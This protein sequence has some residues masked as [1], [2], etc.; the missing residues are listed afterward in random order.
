MGLKWASSAC[1]PTYILKVDDDIV[2]NLESTYKLLTKL[3]SRDNLLMGYMLNNTK[4]KRNKQNK[5]YVTQ[6]EYTWNEYPPY[7]SGWYYIITPDVATKL[8]DLALYY[9]PFWIDDIYITGLVRQAAG[10]TPKQLPENFWLEYYELL[11]CCLTDMISKSIRCDYV[12]G[13]NGGRNNLIVEF[14]EAYRQCETLKKCTTRPNNKPLKKICV[15]ESERNIFSEGK[16]E[17][18]LIAKLK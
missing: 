18:E 12:V 1:T 10:I 8:C 4:P 2:F 3:S 7:L 9:P 11:E 5:W 13:P 14:N 15:V 17:V 6:D 16:G